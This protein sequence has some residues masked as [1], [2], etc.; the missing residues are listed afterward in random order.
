MNLNIQLV[1]PASKPTKQRSTDRILVLK[2]QEGKAKSTTGLTD[3]RLFAGSNELHA[4]MDERTT[5]WF[6]KL[7]YGGL[8]PSLKQRFTDFNKLLEF[9]T[10]YYKKRNIDI[11]EVKD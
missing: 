2:P 6:L 3:P 7:K 9:T 4:I 8:E 11:V 1:D 10:Q 5:L